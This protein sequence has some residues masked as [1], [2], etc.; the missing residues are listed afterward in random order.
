M[1][2]NAMVRG[3]VCV[4]AACMLALSGCGGKEAAV[5]PNVELVLADFANVILTTGEFSEEMYPVP[6]SMVAGMYGITDAEEARVYAGSGATPEEI[7]LFRFADED[8]AAA[9]LELAK[10]RLSDQ[11]R[12]FTDY[13]PDEKYRLEDYAVVEQAGKYV[14]YCISSSDAAA[15]VIASEIS[16]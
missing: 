13:N 2:K 8:A 14:I 15:E 1:K 3:V 7:G 6:D 16:G 9:G 10:Q 5:N 11:K 4:L 12:A